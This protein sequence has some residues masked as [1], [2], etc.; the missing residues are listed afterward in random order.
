MLLSLVKFQVKPSNC[1]GMRKSLTVILVFKISQGSI[2]AQ[3]R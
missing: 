1:D 2:A 3:L